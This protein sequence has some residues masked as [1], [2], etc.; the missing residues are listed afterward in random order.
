MNKVVVVGALIT[1]GAVA[2]AERRPADDP[3]ITTTTAASDT[4]PGEPFGA[5]GG[6]YSTPSA[7]E[8]PPSSAAY[9][10][11]A[12]ADVPKSSTHEQTDTSDPSSPS[13]SPSADDGPGVLAGPVGADTQELERRDRPAAVTATDQGGGTDREITAAIRRSVVGDEALSFGAKN[14]T[15]VTVGGKV[16]LRGAV[17]TEDERAAIEAKA[18]ETAGVSAVDN[19]LEVKR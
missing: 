11:R 9:R 17:K 8:R 10:D 6:V 7:V 16:T 13:R 2:C 12:R 15:I 4:R 18:R 14:V 3:S 1:F 5:R 19:Q